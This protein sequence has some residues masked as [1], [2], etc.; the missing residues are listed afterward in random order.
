ME[1]HLECGSIQQEKQKK[2]LKEAEECVI[3]RI[4][5]KCIA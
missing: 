5:D 1:G 3:N 2:K 4:A